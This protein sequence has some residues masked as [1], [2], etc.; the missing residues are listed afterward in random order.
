VQ[1]FINNIF[2]IL[3]KEIMA[4]IISIS[5]VAGTPKIIEGQYVSLRDSFNDRWNN[6][7]SSIISPPV[8]LTPANP[9][10][11]LLR[12]GDTVTIDYSAD[13]GGN[14]GQGWLCFPN[15][16]AE[17][18]TVSG[19]VYITSFKSL[20]YSD[21]RSEAYSN[22]DR[23]AAS[24]GLLVGGSTILAD[25]SSSFSIKLTG[26]E[27]EAHLFGF[28]HPEVWVEEDENTVTI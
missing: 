9:D 19:N 27:G 22:S 4:S 26:I 25:K 5:S 24:V 8:T 16:K 6:T 23:I 14:D 3:R 10:I 28:V 17:V 12:K 13:V 11:I 15:S 18:T 21:S 1:I 20:K 7:N 2:I